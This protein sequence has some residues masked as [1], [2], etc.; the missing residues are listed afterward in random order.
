MHILCHS[1]QSLNLLLGS[2][3]ATVTLFD[4]LLLVAVEQRSPTWNN[5]MSGRK[6]RA[7]DENIPDWFY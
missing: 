2:V 1:T 6:A 4:Q 5:E 3:L 7:S